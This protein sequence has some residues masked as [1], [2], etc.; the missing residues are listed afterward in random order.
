MNSADRLLSVLDLFTVDKPRW[1]VDE[2]ARRLGVSVSQTYRYVKSLVKA[3]LLDP[4]GGAGGFVLGPAFIAYDRQI[5]LCDPMLQAAR[6]IMRRLAGQGPDGATVLLCR[7]YHERVMC[8]HQ[9]VGRAP[10]AALGYQRGLPMPMLR[11]ASSKIILA[12]LGPRT[13]R[14][15][16]DDH[17]DEAAEAGLGASWD[18]FRAALARIRR[19][20]TVVSVSEIDPQRIG[21]AAP[22][23]DQGGAVIGSL[24]FA[25]PAELAD[26]HL[27]AALTPPTV[28]AARAIEMAMR[29][30]EVVD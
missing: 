2:A 27:L 14:R 23:F 12:H 26:Q 20:G 8:V 1:T 28:A 21:L 15:L 5:Q 6:P 19:A 10:Q 18:E 13:A 29:V 9:V 7:L 3:G 11:G 30:P 25:L 4:A 24:S 17:A 16:Y 22:V